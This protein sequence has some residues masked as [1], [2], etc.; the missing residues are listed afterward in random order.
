MHTIISS[1]TTTVTPATGTI[2]ITAVDPPFGIA[3][4]NGQQYTITGSKFQDG[5]TVSLHNSNKQPSDIV[6]TSV[7]VQSA[8][9]LTCFFD[10]PANSLGNW[11]IIITNPDSTTGT[12]AGGFEVRN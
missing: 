9:R 4:N 1:V 10:I 3:H 6:G 11:D 2:P 12:L 8:T 5:A 7:V